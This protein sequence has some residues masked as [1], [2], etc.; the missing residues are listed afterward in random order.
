M[1][2]VLYHRQLRTLPEEVPLYPL[3]LP[4]VAQCLGKKAETFVIITDVR[5][6][7]SDGP[8]SI[9]RR[10]S[11]GPSCRLN[12][13]PSANRVK[14]Q[15]NYQLVRVISRSFG[16]AVSFGSK[17]HGVYRVSDRGKYAHI[18]P[19]VQERAFA[20]SWLTSIRVWD[21]GVVWYAW[22]WFG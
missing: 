6:L 8:N 5:S 12:V 13:I 15:L 14:Q 3:T 20:D 19:W 17:C 16:Q 22:L 11:H 7:M 18:R 4:G 21:F 9:A 2:T 10:R 1:L